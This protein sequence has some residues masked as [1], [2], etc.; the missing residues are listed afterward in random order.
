MGTRGVFVQGIDEQSQTVRIDGKGVTMGGFADML[1]QFRSLYGDRQERSSWPM[2]RLCGVRQLDRSE[3]APF[4][5]AWRLRASSSHCLPYLE[6]NYFAHERR[7]PH[8]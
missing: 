4:A 7:S 6:A 1:T 2:D 5:L 3:T 8:I